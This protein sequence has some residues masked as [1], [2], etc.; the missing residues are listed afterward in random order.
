MLDDKN[1]NAIAESLINIR[2]TTAVFDRRSKDIDLIIADGGQMMRN[3]AAAS[4]ALTVLLANL[5]RTTGKADRLVDVADVTFKRATRLATDLD[6]TVQS[7]RP[8][9]HQLTTTD[10]ARLDQL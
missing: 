9:L 7:S 4:S 8:G 1:R 2:N 6:A 3:L 5:N 10:T